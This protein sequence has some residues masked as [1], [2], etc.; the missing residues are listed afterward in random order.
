MKTTDYQFRVKSWPPP[1]DRKQKDCYLLG[2]DE[3]NQPYVLRYERQKGHEGWV[4]VTLD[5]SRSS[6]KTAAQRQYTGDMLNKLIKR[7]ADMPL[8][9]RVLTRSAA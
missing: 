1:A 6:G 9:A 5:D 2:F 4:G 7:W 3:D 8:L